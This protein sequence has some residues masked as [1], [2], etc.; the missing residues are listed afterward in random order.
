M[1]WH[2][3]TIS[4]ATCE[5]FPSCRLPEHI[6]F[7]PTLHRSA[8]RQVSWSYCKC[9]CNLAQLL[10]PSIKRCVSCG[11]LVYTLV[12]S[13]TT[14]HLELYLQEVLTDQVELVAISYALGILWSVNIDFCV[15]TDVTIS[16]PMFANVL[17]I[18]FDLFP[19]S[20]W[21]LIAWCLGQMHPCVSQE[22]ATYP[23]ALLPDGILLWWGWEW[24]FW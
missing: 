19:V 22:D 17:E 15:I 6:M 18:V 11:F 13:T 23:A 8:P 2:R 21:P 24:W 20:S 7:H 10:L 5:W 12:P 1:K 16:S 14:V 4:S 3:Y 9:L